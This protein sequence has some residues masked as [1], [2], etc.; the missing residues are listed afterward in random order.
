MTKISV[1]SDTVDF[2]ERKILIILSLIKK[3]TLSVT[4]IFT[5]LVLNCEDVNLRILRF[6]SLI[7]Q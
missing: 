2:F 3:P 4:T 7:S 5:G 1:F 6:L